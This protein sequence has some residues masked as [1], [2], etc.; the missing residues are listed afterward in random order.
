MT[1]AQLLLCAALIAGCSAANTQT[2]EPAEPSKPTLKIEEVGKASMG[3]PRE[4]IAEIAPSMKSD[5]YSE[6]GGILLKLNKRNGERVQAGDVIAE[7]ESKSARIERERA[8]ATLKSAQS[9]LTASSADLTANRLQLT[10]TVKKL[11]AQ[12]KAQTMEGAEEAAL[13]ET[14]RN[15]QAATKQLSAANGNAGIAALEAQ[16]EAAR[17]SLEQVNSA[18]NGGKLI[19]PANG[20]LTDVKATEGM[21]IQ[22]GSPFGI[23]QSTEKV[24]L[25]AWLSE[26]AVEL[27]RGKKEL[28]FTA[29]DDGTARKAKV[30]HL[31]EV[32]D[33]ATRLY[34]LE[35]ES[36]NADR[37][38]KPTE[39][40]QLQ[41]TTKEE[42]NVVAVPSLSIIRE[43]RATF[44][45]VANGSKAEKREVKLGRVNGPFQEVLQGVSAGERLIV[46]GQHSLAD[47]QTIEAG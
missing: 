12:L 37:A 13:E 40:V 26:T 6:S 17:L 24:K 7:F 31:A 38:L 28:V 4:Q 1:V 16:V 22:A 25:K 2:G 8:E 41:L 42:E 10:N 43:G 23:V 5:I 27:V 3:N 30:L 14:K 39:R 29:S 46:S 32:P 47:G 21:T 11:E 19:A 34:A 44:V 36:D 35:L 18:W 9:S 45:F 15:L 20:V 33:A